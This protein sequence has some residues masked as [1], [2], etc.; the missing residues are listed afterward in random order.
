M[1][2]RV[3]SGILLFAVLLCLLPPQAEAAWYGDFYYEV[4]F[5]GTVTITGYNGSDTTVVI[6]S[7]IDG[8]KVSA[9]GLYR[10]FDVDEITNIYIPDGVTKIVE[11]AFSACT[12]L[13]SIRLPETLTYIGDGAF[14]GCT[15]LTS[16]AIPDGVTQLGSDTPV[17][18]DWNEN[19]WKGGEG[20]FE[21]CTGLRSVTLPDTLE[22]IGSGTFLG[23]SSLQNI[24]IPDGVTT[25]GYAAFAKCSSLEN[26]EIPEGVTSLGKIVPQN[27]EIV[28]EN[29][30][31][32]SYDGVNFGY[33][34]LNSF[35]SSPY[36]GVFQGCSAMTRVWLPDSMTYIG[37]KTFYGC[38]NLT[39]I[40]FPKNLTTIGR[41]AFRDCKEF[42]RVTLPDSVTVIGDEAFYGCT[43]LTNV[44]LPAS[45]TK[46]GSNVFQK[47][48]LESVTFAG[49]SY[50]W[51]NI[52]KEHVNPELKDIVTVEQIDDSVVDEGD[53]LGI[54]I[55]AG[56][57]LVIAVIVI[58]KKV[59]GY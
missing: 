22:T 59:R 32:G 39:D 40:T 29:S 44:Y 16:I 14:A 12:A 54:F 46:L 48:D 43:S 38:T 3:F 35:D 31:E 34:G 25:I 58:V 2:K 53:Y 9:V 52:Y 41:Y 23:C 19:L 17:V 28:T 55:F 5:D 56:I 7:E 8:Y 1:I 11:G 4:E 30:V 37:E 26:I 21:G 13:R 24:E 50:Q 6:P 36:I 42:H 27:G 51:M 33:Y 45:L 47:T 57:A 10:G 49:T 20:V 18:F 15:R